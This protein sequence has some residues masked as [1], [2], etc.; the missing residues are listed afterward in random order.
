[1]SK[2]DELLSRSS[3]EDKTPDDQLSP[4]ALKR[5]RD[6]DHK[7]RERASKRQKETASTALIEREFWLGNRSSIPV[8]ELNELQAQH[9][10]IHDLLDLM[11]L[12]GEEV[13]AEY[14]EHLDYISVGEVTAKVIESVKKFGTTRLG[15]IHKDIEIPQDWPSRQYW[16]EPELLAKLEAENKQTAIHAR[17][18]LTIAIPDWLAVGFLTDKAGWK[19]EAAYQLVGYRLTEGIFKY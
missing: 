6:R 2:R 12:A 7:R 17:Y 10:R 8:K 19:H 11:E 14:R 3:R 1:M 16:R 9:E 13:P 5:K 4:E 15:Y 18:G